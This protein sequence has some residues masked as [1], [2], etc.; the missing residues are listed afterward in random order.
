MSGPDFDL[1]IVGAGPAGMSAAIRAR[2]LGLSVLV[3]DEQPAPGGQIYRAIER[4]S[5]ARRLAIFGADHDIGL[6]LVERFRAAGATYWPSTQV[7]QAEPGWT[8]FATRDRT[9]IIA[10][11]RHVLIAV[12]AMERPLPFRGWTLPG[13]MTVGAAQILLKEGGLLPRGPVVIAGQ[14]PLVL[15][16]AAQ[17]LKLGVK[18]DAVLL[19]TARGALMRGATHGLGALRNWPYLV[20][21][22]ALMAAVRAAPMPMLR[23][24]TDLT[25]I[26]GERLQTVEY[27]LNGVKR[28]RPASTLLVHDGVVPHAHMSLALGAAHSWDDAQQCYRP[29]TDDF[30]RTSIASLSVAGDAG[31]IGG[32]AL[33]ALAGECAALGV[34]ADL[35]RVETRALAAAIS[36]LTRQARRHRH[37]RPFLDAVYRPHAGTHL[38]DDVVVCRCEERTAGDIRAGVA[39]GCL[40]PAQVKSFTRAGMGPCQGRQCTLTIAHVIAEARGVPV[41]TL[42]APRIRPP[43]KPVTLGELAALATK[44]QVS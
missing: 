32:A 2:A 12:G 44:A 22:A 23:G 4:M 11:A 30:G 41:A 40:G 9:T 15:L 33:A 28:S 24:V 35:D 1:A 42:D 5:D 36:D 7:W 43:L 3:V 19:T 34:A 29:T 39:A 10:K 16:F 20:K 18:P 31:G 27:T 8:L 38:P 37:V 14:G 13:V 6:A 17:L 26:G 21:G 25:S